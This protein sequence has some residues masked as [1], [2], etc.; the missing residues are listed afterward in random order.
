MRTISQQ[1]GTAL[2]DRKDWVGVRW[3]K[4]GEIG[5][6]EVK[7]L[8]YA[9]GTGSITKAIGPLVTKVVGIDVS[10]NMVQKYN[11]QAE[12][13]GLSSEQVRAVVGDLL[14]DEVSA[15]LKTP[16]FY[17]FDL[18]VVGLGFHHFENP[19]RAIERLTERLKADTGVLMI[20]DFLPF[21]QT[22]HGYAAQNTIKHGGF[23]KDNL[24]KLHKTAKLQKF[25][26]SVV[27]EPAVME[28]QD[29]TVKRTLFISRA[30]KEPT[31]WG[32]FSNWVYSVQMMASDQ[33][34][35]QVDPNKVNDKKVPIKL[36]LTGQ[37]SGPHIEQKEDEWSK[38]VRKVGW[39]PGV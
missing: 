13:A 36:G 35:F 22:E 29:G 10:E 2:L 19:L 1:I 14:A 39:N 11:E 15:A 8:D 27:D 9:C 31:A 20:V 25:S 16:E 37:T 5:G 34:R 3:Y 28:L 24:E 17:E 33:A 4:P 7:M 32:K 21:D 30:R 38:N 12:A 23:T 26:F 18:A 6:R